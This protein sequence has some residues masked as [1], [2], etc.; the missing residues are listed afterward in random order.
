MILTVSINGTYDNKF[1][2]RHLSYK[3]VTVDR[4]SVGH[5]VDS[6]KREYTKSLVITYKL[7]MNKFFFGGLKRVSLFGIIKVTYLR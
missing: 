4:T 7:C 2:L 1:Y 6:I 5:R 3:W